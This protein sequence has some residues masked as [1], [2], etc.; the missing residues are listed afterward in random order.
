MAHEVETMAYAHKENGSQEYHHPWHIND[1][2]DRSV[3]IE[4]GITVAEMRTKSGLDWTVERAEGF[5]EIADERIYTGDDYL[6]RSS[7]NKILTSVSPDWHEVG[8]EAFV[9]FFHEFCEA[10]TMEMN[11]MGSLKG[12]Q[13]LFAAAKLNEGFSLLDGKDSIETY[14]MFSNPIQYGRSLQIG[15]TMVRP[16][17]D[18]TV[19]LALKGIDNS[20]LHIRLDHRKEF[21]AEMVKD[22]LAISRENMETFKEAA[23]FLASKKFK[24]DDMVEYYDNLFPSKSKKDEEKLSRN[25]QFCVDNIDEQPGH[26]LGEGTWWQAFNG[27]TYLIDHVKGR[28]ENNRLASAQFGSGRKKKVEALN[29]AIE[30]AEAA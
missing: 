6:Y 30:Y 3:P 29:T 11:T 8:P 7:D 20:S 4:P 25:A 1:T 15:T 13:H 28:N 26:E 27:V 10:G 24:V 16:V 5:V 9:D 12:G 2:R 22:T 19:T 18:N 17:C 23:E 14:L 21:D